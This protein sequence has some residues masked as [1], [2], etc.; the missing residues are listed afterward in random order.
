MNKALGY[1]TSASMHFPY[2]P[3]FYYLGHLC[4]EVCH[5][6]FIS[7]VL[8]VL[9]FHIVAAL[10]QGI[11]GFLFDELCPTISVVLHIPLGLYSY[12]WISHQVMTVSRKER[13]DYCVGWMDLME[14]V[15]TFNWDKIESKWGIN[16]CKVP[17]QSTNFIMLIK[18]NL[19]AT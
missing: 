19:Q 16:R 2:D 15:M 6:M 7:A 11:F 4:P 5:I 8:V 13:R 9:S 1:D 14:H 10:C 12:V 17:A 3:H 18:Y